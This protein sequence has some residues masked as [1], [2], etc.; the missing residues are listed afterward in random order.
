MSWLFVVVGF[1]L[2][3]Q[4]SRSGT[5]NGMEM[6]KLDYEQLVT[7][8]IQI[9]DFQAEYK[10]LIDSGNQLY[11][12]ISKSPVMIVSISGKEDDIPTDMLTLFENPDKLITQDELV[13]YSWA[14]RIR[15]V[16]YKV[17]GQNHQ[18]LTAIKPDSLHIQH[19]NKVYKVTHGIISFTLQQLSAENTYQCIVHPKMLTGVPVQ[20]AS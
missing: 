20:S 2:A 19:D 8:T 6:T 16:P 13:D 11:D 14:D 1:P 3:W 18:L 4:F 5:L 7:V 17:I 9:G 12:P 15:V 10:G